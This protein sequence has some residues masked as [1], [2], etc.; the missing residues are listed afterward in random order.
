MPGRF[1]DRVWAPLFAR[2]YDRMNA[3]GE[4]AGLRDL[5]RDLLAHA[6]GRTLEVGA[7]T[8]ANLPLYPAEVTE[9]VLTEPD[10]HMRTQLEAKGAEVVAAAAEALPFAAADFDTAVATLVLCSASEQASVLRELARVLRPGGS[11]LFLE[12]VRSADPRVARRQ[13]RWERPWSWI[14]RGCHPNRDTLAAIRAAGFEVVEVAH[15]ALPSSPAIVR[16]L[17]VGE[18]R[19]P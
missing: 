13:D 14:G 6:R 11:L 2:L 7:G 3:R 10:A 17:I 12:H 9:L 19:R 15:E 16:P 5:R 4:N 1:S 18:A 8:G